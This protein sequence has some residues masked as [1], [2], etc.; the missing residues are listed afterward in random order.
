MKKAQKPQPKKIKKLVRRPIRHLW[1]LLPLALIIWSL[2][3]QPAEV[4]VLSLNP[5]LLDAGLVQDCPLLSR[6]TQY[7]FELKL[8]QKI[9]KG[10]EAN[11]MLT[12]RAPEGSVRLSDQQLSACSLALETNLAADDL[13]VEPGNILIEPFV[14][15]VSQVFL[16]ALSLPAADSAAGDLWISAAVKPLAAASAQRL[17]LFSIPVVVSAAAIFGLPPALVRYLAL[18]IMLIPLAVSFRRRLLGRE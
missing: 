3:P 16:Y 1:L 6:L 7:E 5:D 18:L 8:P 13:S 15:N 2:W 17:P 11:L 4:R 10:E 9:W 12:L 14:G